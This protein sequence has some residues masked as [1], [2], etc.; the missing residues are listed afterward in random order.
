MSVFAFVLR[1]TEFVRDANNS[2]HNDDKIQFYLI[3][4]HIK[5]HFYDLLL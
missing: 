1:V 5:R 2:V 4:Y 3:R